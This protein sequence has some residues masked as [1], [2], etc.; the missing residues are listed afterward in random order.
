MACTEENVIVRKCNGKLGNVVLT[1]EGIIRKCPDMSRMSLS[2]K[3]MEQVRRFGQ[4]VAYAREVVKDAQ[5]SNYY[6]GFVKRMKTKPYKKH[7][8][9]SQAAI[10][11][12]LHPPEIAE[13]KLHRMFDHSMELVVDARGILSDAVVTVCFLGP[14]GRLLWACMAEKQRPGN[15]FPSGSHSSTPPERPCRTPCDARLDSSRKLTFT[16]RKKE[17]CFVKKKNCKFAVL[18]PGTIPVAGI[19]RCFLNDFGM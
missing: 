16:P 9:I 15:R 10:M 2:A 4:A 5:M 8:G 13:V 14:D 1:R 19:T 7:M 17:S 11:D 3:Q 18:K 6:A 12:F